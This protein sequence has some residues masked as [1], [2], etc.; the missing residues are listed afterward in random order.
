[1]E[2]TWHCESQNFNR[3][4]HQRT[5]CECS[6]PCLKVIGPFLEHSVYIEVFTRINTYG[7]NLCCN[8]G[9][10]V[11]LGELPGLTI[12]CC[13]HR[14]AGSL[15]LPSAA[16]LEGLIGLIQGQGDVLPAC[17]GISSCNR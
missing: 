15:V 10:D 16:V 5:A 13:R 17:A 11:Q 2:G 12:V 6:R 14:S 9:W 4:C 7:C 1:M 8:H 3:T